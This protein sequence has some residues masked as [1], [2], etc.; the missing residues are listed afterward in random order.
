LFC[1]D[2]PDSQS[3]ETISTGPC[4]AAGRCVSYSI[5]ELEGTT[6]II[7]GSTGT[8]GGDMAL[9]L[10]DAGCR[11]VCHYHSNKARA[12][13][14]VEEI[15][16]KGPDAA[17]VC[18]DLSCPD[19]IERLFSAA[20]RLGPVRILI[21]SAAVFIRQRL[22][23]ITADKARQVFDT[24]L[25]API[26]ASRRFACVVKSQ[27][28]Q[29]DVAVAGIINIADVGGIRPWAKYTLYCAS[30]AGLIAVT[31]SLARELAPAIRVNA[32]APGLVSWPENFT[33]KAKQRQLDRIPMARVATPRD[34]TAAVIFLLKNDYITGQVLNVDGGRCI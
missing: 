31:K 24:N 7:T 26:L 3:P 1:P 9:S 34:I 33:E 15:R 2:G 21:N 25:V 6:A 23:D 4:R 11:C 18:A 29:T 14:I 16:R 19:E 17:A 27:I 30:K 20:E 10:A 12:E 28:R 22:E 13:R 32:I 5:M 8:L